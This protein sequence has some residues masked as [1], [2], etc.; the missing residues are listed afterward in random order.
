LQQVRCQGRSKFTV[1]ALRSIFRQDRGTALEWVLFVTNVL[2]DSVG[3]SGSLR[4]AKAVV[5]GTALLLVALM[6]GV[7]ARTAG[8]ASG[9]LVD[10]KLGA[11]GVGGGT[12]RTVMQVVLSLGE[13]PGGAVGSQVLAS[14]MSPRPFER[15]LSTATSTMLRRVRRLLRRFLAVLARAVRHW[16][17][18]ITAVA[19][20]AVLTLLAPL[21]DRGLVRTWRRYGFRA[22]RASVALIL[23][24]YVRL[25]LDAR[26]PVIGKCLLV[27]AL[28]YGASPIDVL[29][30][31]RMPAGFIDDCLVV[32]IASQCFMRLCPDGLVEQHALEATR[33]RDRTLRRRMAQRRVIGPRYS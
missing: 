25:L 32:V 19:V 33:A 11:V 23:A 8:L 13:G 10:A 31:S 27:L 30:D 28:I 29:P 5:G 26:A 14:G 3:S 16:A 2:I 17:R 24:V 21:L 18:R 20:F 9:A 22:L 12:L 6:I 4:A 15:Q 1:R 7:C